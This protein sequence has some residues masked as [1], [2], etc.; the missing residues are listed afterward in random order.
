VNVKIHVN[1]FIRKK[2][3]MYRTTKCTKMVDLARMKLTIVNV[4]RK[5][6][7][8]LKCDLV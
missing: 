5:L 1:L 6:L 4:Y 3:T 7:M 2:E 8:M